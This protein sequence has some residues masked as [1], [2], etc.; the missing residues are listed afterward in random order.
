MMI[1]RLCIKI[2]PIETNFT[3]FQNINSYSNEVEYKITEK[4]LIIYKRKEAAFTSHKFRGF[5]Y[6]LNQ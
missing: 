1:F 5:K 2:N 3:I 6:K 4:Q